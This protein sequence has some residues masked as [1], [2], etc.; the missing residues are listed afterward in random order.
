[1]SMSINVPTRIQRRHPIGD[2]SVT[3][4]ETHGIHTQAKITA[5]NNEYSERRGD[6][7]GKE[8]VEEG[9][10]GD[11]TGICLWERRYGVVHFMVV[12]VIVATDR[13]I[14]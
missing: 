4:E 10:R 12:V 11:G 3:A 9:T 13:G 8:Q 5:D 2:G 1:M 14:V 6:D 7:E